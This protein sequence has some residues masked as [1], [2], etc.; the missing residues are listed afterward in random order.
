MIKENY[1]RI[2]LSMLMDDGLT[3]TH[4]VILGYLNTYQ[5]KPDGTPTNNFVYDTQSNLSVTLGIGISTLKD[6]INYLE[7]NG[8]IFKTTKNDIDDKPQFKNRK[9]IIMVDEHN[10]LPINYKIPNLRKRKI[11]LAVLSE[12]KIK[13]DH[14]PIEEEIYQPEVSNELLPTNYERII[15]N[16]SKPLSEE[17]LKDIDIWAQVT[18]EMEENRPIKTL[19]MANDDDDEPMVWEKEDV[20]K[21]PIS[22]KDELPWNINSIDLLTKYSKQLIDENPSYITKKSTI[23]NM[24]KTWNL[25]SKAEVLQEYN[26]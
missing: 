19:T 5:N 18:I 3:L 24:I 6:A 8:Y 1:I 9:A 22:D 21:N 13:M 17:D 14:Q 26:K 20:I 7:A 10:P 16:V 15:E 4:K 2:P 23:E 25:K 12:E 11:K